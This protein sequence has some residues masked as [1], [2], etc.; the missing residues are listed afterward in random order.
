VLHRLIEPGQYTS[1]AYTERLDDI[2]AA[3]SIGTIGDSFDNAMAEA[4]N[5]LYKWELIYPQGPWRGLDDVEFATLG[6]I[7]WFNHRRLHGEI[8]DDNSYVTPAEFEATYYRQAAPALEA[9]TQT[10]E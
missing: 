5:S 10:T 1:I 7:D 6:Y 8:T 3:P 4:F 2:G 9:V